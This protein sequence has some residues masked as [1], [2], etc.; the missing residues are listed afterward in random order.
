M[1]LKQVKSQFG[2][3]IM[4]MFENEKT[5]G[6]FAEN[7][8]ID[9]FHKKFDDS[10]TRIQKDFGQNYPMII[11]GKEIFSNDIFEVRSPADR[12]LILGRFPLATKED[13]LHAI[14]TARDSFFKWALVPYETRVRIFREVADIF[15]QNKFDLAAIL[16]FENGKNRLEAMGDLDESIDFMR[17]YAEQLEINQ[18]FSKQTKSA[19]SNENTKSVLKP[20]GVWGI[21]SPFNFPSAIAIGMTS[22]ALITGNTVVLKPSS[23]AP[24]SAFKFVESIY[25]KLPPAAINFVTGSGSIVGKTI[26]SSDIIEGIAFTGSKQVGM[27][28]YSTVT[29]HRPRPFISEMGGKNPAIVSASSD[30]EKATDGVMR[31]AFGYSG[32]KCSAC[33]RVYVH[34]SIA[35]KFLDML[36][37]KTRA[38]KVGKPWEKDSYI[39]PVINADAVQKFQNASNIAKK[40][41]KILCGGDLVP[42]AS[43]KDGNF[44]MPTIVAGLPKDHELIREELFL[45][46]LCVEEFDNFDEAISLANKSNYGLTAGV[47]SQ[48]RTEIEK[49]FEKIEAGVTY[50]NRA[51]SATT[52]AM[53]GAQPFVGWK[54]S[55]ISGKGA[56]GAYYLLQFLREQTQTRCE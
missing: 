40:D 38:L 7:N 15:S 42:D 11:G 28:G 47:F 27:S 36:V 48:D 29:S 32:Q 55:G 39:G 13:T 21:I 12:N 49:F 26:L 44:V 5:Y 9:E 2:I 24:I 31:A 54:D 8:S 30:I 56:G 34:K 3:L 53:V 4:T 52:G 20:Y 25:H 1:T 41:G 37:A 35:P 17:F 10:V 46:F 50:A 45:P 43:C 33:S 14:E 22:G 23:D 51:A 6:R 18:G 16:S 19:T